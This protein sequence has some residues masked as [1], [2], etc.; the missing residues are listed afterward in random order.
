MGD[1]Y[2]IILTGKN[3]YKEAEL[4]PEMK[5]FRIGTAMEC[6]LR[7]RRE[8]YFEPVELT[9][10]RNGEVWTIL[11]ANNLFLNI[12]D[13]RK[14]FT[15][16]LEHG[17]TFRVCYQSS[18][19]ELLSVEF[20]I[21]FENESK[22]LTRRIDVSTLQYFSIGVGG[23]NQIVLN[24]KYLRR[25]EISCIQA[26]GALTITVNNTTYGI[27]VNGR[28]MT[29]GVTVQSGNFFSLSD[30]VFYYNNGYLWTDNSDVVRTALPV[31]VDTR[32]DEYPLFHRNTRVKV[33]P[34]EEKI[35]ILDP[36]QKPEKPKANLFQRLFPSLGMLIAAGIMAYMGGATMLIFSGISGLMA[37]ITAIVSIVQGK[38]EFKEKTQERIEKYEVYIEG[39][40]EEI[41]KARD[42]ERKTLEE[43]YCS[44]IENINRLSNFSY[45][46]FDRDRGDADFL[47]VRLGTGA[48]EANRKI[49]YKKQERLEIED[50]L[51]KKP[52]EIFEEFRNVESAPVVC[53]LK[54]TNAVGVVGEDDSRWTMLNRM[55]IDIAARHYYSDVKMFFIASPEH[56]EYVWRFRMLP[57]VYNDALKTRNIVCNESSKNLIFEYLYK[58][59][60]HREQNK[61]QENHFVIF[62]LD[63]N[64]IKTHPISRF[65]EKA[66]DLGVT[67]VFFAQSR[68]DIAQGCGYLINLTGPCNG[69]LVNASDSSKDTPFVCSVIN[70]D[71]VDSMISLLSPVYTEEISLESSLTKNI[72]LFQLLNILAVDDLNLNKRWAESK[73]YKSMSA[74]LGVSKSGVVSLDL[75][76][77]FHGPHGLVAGTTGSGK[78]ELLQSYVLSM[79]TL[80]HP[81]EVGFVIIDFKGGGMANQFRDLPHL[82]GTITNI[83]GRE[84]NRSLKSIKA[85]LQKRFA[86]ADVN[87]IDKYIQKYKAGEVKEALPHLIII[88]DEFAELKAE[89]PEFMKELISAARIG[90]SLGVHLI[91]ATQ[92]PAGQVNEQIWSNSRFKLCLKVQ[93]QE[94]SNEVLKSPLAAEIR[95]PGRAYLQVG[96][97]EIFELFQSAYSGAPEHSDDLNVKEFTVYELADNGR[98]IPVFSQKKQKQEGNVTTQ[99]DALVRYVNGYCK[100]KNIRKLP[101]ICLPSLATTITYPSELI[102]KTESGHICVDLGI[103]DDP[104]NQFQGV[105]S[106][107]FTAQNVIV[108]GS[109]LSGKTNVLQTMVRGLASR[110]T[111]QE[112]SIYIIDFASLVMKNFETLHHVGGVVLPSQDEKLKNLMKLLKTDMKQRKEK[113]LAVGVSSFA[114]YKEAGKTDMPQI[115]LMIDNLTSLKEMYFQDD[116]DIL[117]LCREGLAVGISVVITNAQ[118]TG[119]GYKYLSNFSGRLALFCNDYGEYSSLFNYCRERIPDIHGRSL[120]EIDKAHLECQMFLAFEGD[121]EFERVEKIKEFIS[122]TNEHFAGMSAR[123]IPMIPENLTSRYIFEKYASHMRKP[124][125]FV[126][127]IDYGVV[128]PFCMQLNGRGAFGISGKAKSGKANFLRYLITAFSTMYPGKTEVY[129]VDGVEKKLNGIQTVENVIQYELRSDQAIEI[130]ASVEQRLAKRYQAL[131]DDTEVDDDN[132][133]LLLLNSRD[134]VEAIS[135]NGVALS[136]YNNIVGKYKSLNVFVIIGDLENA[137]ISYTAPE[138]YKKI[139]ETRQLFFFDDLEKLKLVDVSLS[140][141]KSYKKP[142]E[143]GDCFYIC[144]NACCKVKTPILVN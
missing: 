73:V 83:D 46:L 120:I 10:V 38:K 48:V 104:D 53:D 74:P 93:T 27:Y 63:D 121:R 3:L 123:Q 13:A 57:Y 50:D 61:N 87:H 131:A 42:E 75:H 77:R 79:A 52:G 88:V 107:D 33:V 109:A 39:K 62:V 135:G 115:V 64:G 84:I 56:K 1:R 100:E 29:S 141:I 60:S 142:I 69:V 110:Y 58:E 102:G 82:L 116:D 21:D 37:I 9:L 55:I 97:N 91:L 101:N 31:Y 72:T 43:I 32:G 103:Y 18:G 89:Q 129:V 49:E 34:S 132:F 112:V 106:V 134:A 35:E 113:M 22:K 90:R 111:P 126:A 17:Y 59:L 124:G 78:S 80:F 122:K 140:V 14:L 20:L 47:C 118:T 30:A 85:E 26:N 36:P 51:Q 41:T 71:T 95:E 2:R 7:L 144:D 86:G 128:E 137:N 16:Q 94:D 15:M 25:D 133:I 138:I 125:E 67:F 40:R 19:S 139:R 99:L 105:Y 119:I 23:N 28:K 68:A 143:A 65:I 130:V 114:A 76:D 54:S 66:K 44:D 70:K 96:N 12:G 117:A 5:E 45:N 6:D 92:K 136:A 98:R 127:G 8:Q 4:L 24:S 11:C 81:Y 108:I